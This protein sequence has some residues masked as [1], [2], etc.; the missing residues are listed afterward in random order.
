MVSIVWSV[1]A[2]STGLL[3]YLLPPVLGPT[4]PMDLRQRVGDFYYAQAMRSFRQVAFVRRV[5]GGYE[6]LPIS[7]DDEQKLA[8][9]TL[10]SGMLSSDKK[11]PFKDP[12]SRIKRLHQKPVAL[13]IEEAPAAIDAELAELGYWLRQHETKRGLEQSGKINPYLPM[14]KGLRLVDPLDFV[15]LVSKNVE[16]ENVET[17]KQLTEKRF[18]EYGR[19]IGMAETIGTLTGFGV[20]IGAIAAVQYFKTEIMD[21]GGGGAS[22]PTTPVPMGQ[23]VPAM[24]LSHIQITMTQMTMDVLTVIA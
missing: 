5:L 19:D 10:D 11:L 1:I 23:V 18:E 17:T 3:V 2:I 24:D 14:S 16:P 13:A 8:Q 9:V 6:L 15:N 4:L 20:G 12:D 7:V 22:Q 21:A